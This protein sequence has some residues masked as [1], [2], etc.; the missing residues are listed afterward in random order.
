[1]KIKRKTLNKI[2][3]FLLKVIFV[4]FVI[5]IFYVIFKTTFIRV[6]NFDLVN[7]KDEYKERVNLSLQE[8]INQKFFFVPKN[9]LVTYSGKDFK[10]RTKEILTNAKDVSV[11]P[12]SLHTIRVKVEN[13]NP[14]FRLDG[15]NIAIS[16]EGVPYIELNDVS[17][18]PLLLSSSTVPVELISK[19]KNFIPKV[20]TVL[21]KADV[22]IVDEYG[23]IY[24]KN[25][26]SGSYIIFKSKD[27]LEKLWI[28]LLSAI[29]T[30]PLK[31]SLN[32][33]LNKL[34]Y[35]D[36]RF[37]NKVFY[38]FTNATHQDIIATSTININE[39]TTTNTGILAEPNRQ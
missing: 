10:K 20:D 2:L 31:D 6:Y 3:K 23:D 13:Y 37:G 25:N 26:E 14:A 4:A 1:M 15:I 22:V 35:I 24:L 38:K 16:D 9:N 12:V 28:T 19:I 5:G 21:F 30:A 8:S 18:L 39:S 11:Y 34:S 7:I 27:D 17:S 29:E 33:E 36:V 32:S